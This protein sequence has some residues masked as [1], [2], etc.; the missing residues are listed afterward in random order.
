[1]RRYCVLLLIALL[2]VSS[3][4]SSS[5]STETEIRTRL[6]TW[7]LDFNAKNISEVCTLFAPDLI[8]SYQGQ[9]DKNYDSMCAHLS[10]SLGKSD[11]MLRYSLQIEEILVSG[12]MAIA[13]VIWT[14]HVSQHGATNES[15]A[16]DRGIDV[17]KRQT[18]G[19]WRIS[20]FIA[21][22]LPAEFRTETSGGR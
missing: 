3:V 16:Q 6:K 8:A 9:S 13:R 17:F 10:A 1:M 19:T 22:P 11:K 5:E 21:Y 2:L 14:L 20:R 18:D 15:V 12:D 4:V 7:M